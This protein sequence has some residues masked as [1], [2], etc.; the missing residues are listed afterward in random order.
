MHLVLQRT[1]DEK[2]NASCP[3]TLLPPALRPSSLDDRLARYESMS[4]DPAHANRVF[5]NVGFDRLIPQDI[6]TI[7][8]D[9]LV[10][11]QR[12]FVAHL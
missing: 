2:L 12:D 3:A 11:E 9:D 8:R 1:D 5:P 7:I 10:R 6:L 4:M